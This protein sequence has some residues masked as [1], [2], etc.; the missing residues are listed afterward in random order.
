MTGTGSKWATGAND[1]DPGDVV[2]VISGTNATAGYYVVESVTSDTVMTLM[3]SIGDGGGTPSAVEYEIYAGDG[4]SY[5]D[6]LIDI[7]VDDKLTIGDSNGYIY[8][9]DA[10]VTADGG[11]EPSH[12][13]YTKAFDGGAPEMNKRIDAVS[14]D[15]KGTSITVEYSLDDGTWTT[16]YDAV[17][18]VS[19]YKS[20]RRF[21]NKSGK[22][23]QFRM[24][25]LFTIRSWSILNVMPED[26][27]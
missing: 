19:D 24:S 7:Q 12:Y 25:G 11:V 8:Q 15:A 13:Y 14:I 18:L 9:E 26:N 27:R 20:Y 21:I 16:C 6:V 2:K 23:I 17:A 10:T 3:T 5:D 4:E 22:K 1:V